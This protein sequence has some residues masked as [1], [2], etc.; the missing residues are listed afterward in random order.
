MKPSAFRMDYFQ[1][2]PK[3]VHAPDGFGYIPPEP[4]SVSDGFLT[5]RP[6][7][8]SY[9]RQVHDCFTQTRSHFNRFASNVAMKPC[10]LQPACF[11]HGHGTGL[12]PGG[13]GPASPNTVRTSDGLL[14]TRP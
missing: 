1:R 9:F 11:Q 4:G 14:P 7:S 12:V 6:Q 10:A 13:F 3:P 8:R 5:N 2:Y